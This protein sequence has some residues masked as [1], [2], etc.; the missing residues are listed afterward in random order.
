[1]GTSGLSAAEVG[2][3]RYAQLQHHDRDEDGDDA[4]TERRQ[5]VFSH[6]APPGNEPR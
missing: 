1:M 3:V 4:V 2:A 5:A 6:V